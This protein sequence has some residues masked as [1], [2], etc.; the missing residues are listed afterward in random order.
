MWA[1]PASV[2]A[3]DDPYANYP[4]TMD[5][6]GVARDFRARNVNGG[7]PDMELSPPQGYALYSGVVAN[8][9]DSEGK[10]AFASTGYKVTT[11]ATDSLGRPVIGPK[12][13]IAARTGD[14]APLVSGSQGSV[15]TSSSRFAQWYRDTPGVNTSRAFGI[16]LARQPGTNKYVFDGDI[17]AHGHPDS[18]GFTVNGQHTANALGG[19]PNFDITYESSLNFTF[20]AG[21][22]QY[23]T[24][25]SD[26]DMWVYIDGKLVIDLG[27]MH[28]ATWQNIDLDRLGW[29][30]D[31][32][33]YSV[34][35][36]FAERHK[37]N[38]KFHFETNLELQ[39]VPLPPT[40][41]L[42]D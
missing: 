27:G 11:Q 6:N 34:K 20:R 19:N 36:F 8:E 35:V 14:N 16:Y 41:G 2:T 1:A 26:D 21:R 5:V 7:H 3:V 15:L 33:P 24:F 32:H 28:S 39:S 12:P 17:A 4:A 40:S 31:N 29:L 25:A 13:Y 37:T 10:P 9:L 38:S 23:F 18:G 22:G 30:V 42:A